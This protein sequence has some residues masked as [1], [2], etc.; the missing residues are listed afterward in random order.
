MPGDEASP[1]RPSQYCWTEQFGLDVKLVGALDPEGEPAVLDGSLDRS[2][3]DVSALL[4]WPDATTPR[5]VV[6]ANHH[7]PPANLKRLLRP[8]VAAGSVR[9]RVAGARTPSPP[10]MLPG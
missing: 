3:G 5:T 10:P 6:A 8:P 2:P 9:V 7:T 4:A 1:Y